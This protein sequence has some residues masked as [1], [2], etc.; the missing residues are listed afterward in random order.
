MVPRY[1][2]CVEDQLKVVRA[3][4][5]DRSPCAVV[6]DPTDVGGPLEPGQPAILDHRI[7]KLL[8][9][10]DRAPDIRFLEPIPHCLRGRID[11]YRIVKGR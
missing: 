8:D 5:V 7:P 4:M 10:A 11:G 3:F 1:L 9:G 6:D 2:R